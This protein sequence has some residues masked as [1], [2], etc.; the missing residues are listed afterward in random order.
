MTSTPERFRYELPFA[1]HSLLSQTRLPKQIR[2]YLSPTAVIIRH[3]N[4]TLKHLKAHIKRLDS[5][6]TIDKLFDKLVKI[7]LE[8]ADYGP[9][10]K[11]LPIIKEFQS[12]SQ[13]IMVCDDDQY[14]HPY[15][16]STLIKYSTEYE[17]SIIGLRG[18]RGK[19]FF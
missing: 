9:A 6:K 18:W 13:A 12:K 16:L 17:K 10:T 19:V 7:R 8:Q 15:T 2:I 5:S 3:R 11:Y 4:L 1:I 14:Y